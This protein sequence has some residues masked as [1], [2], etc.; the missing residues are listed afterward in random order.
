[1]RLV[2]KHPGFD[3]QLPETEILFIHDPG[4]VPQDPVAGLF[5]I[6]SAELLQKIRGFPGHTQHFRI[7]FTQAEFFTV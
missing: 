3:P 7:V 4:H 5:R 2:R 1:M 6:S